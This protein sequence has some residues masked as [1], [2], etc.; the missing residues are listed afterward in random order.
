MFSSFLFQS[1]AEKK[2][3]R[4]RPRLKKPP[5]VF[6]TRTFVN[7][8]IMGPQPGALKYYRVCY[9]TDDWNDDAEKFSLRTAIEG[10]SR[11]LEI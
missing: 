1:P 11:P 2:R 7:G 3:E 4:K 8:S 10:V 5:S 9:G 6:F